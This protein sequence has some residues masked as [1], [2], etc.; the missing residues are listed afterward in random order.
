M[1]GVFQPYY[2]I[3]LLKDQSSS[4]I[5]WVGAIQ[6][7]LLLVVGVVT[8][9]LYDA[10]YFYVLVSTGSVLNVV[11]FM[12]L[13]GCTEYWQVL[14]AQ[15]FCVGVS[16]FLRR[17]VPTQ[18]YARSP[19]SEA[20]AHFDRIL[21][22]QGGPVYAVLMA[23]FFGYIGFF[24]PIFYIEAYA[25]QKH[26]ME[27]TLAF[28]LVSILNAASIPGRIVPGLLGLRFGPLNILLG[29][30]IISGILSLSWIA[31]SNAGG[32]IALAVLYGFFSGAF[33]SLPAVALTTLTP[34]LQTLG[35]RMGMCSLLCGFGSLCGAPVAGAILDDT[36]SYLGV[37][38]YSGL[39]VGTT[40]VLLF[41]ASLLK[42]RTN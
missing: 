34:N 33:V 36:R 26:A 10:G 27:E 18:R 8:G 23:M 22:V 31:V 28:Y 29:S 4:N 9:P 14:L 2:E 7:F 32:L 12:A 37:Q 39:T 17:I 1:F 19:S 20:K 13:S 40:G 41:F 38:L 15:A 5:S 6:A 21:C 16:W 11:G 30:A 24:N 42:G 25:I 3:T 35:T